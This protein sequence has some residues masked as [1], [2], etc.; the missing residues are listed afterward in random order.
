MF[1]GLN[2]VYLM[3]QKS[4]PE[5]Y[6]KYLN[7]DSSSKRQEEDIL[8]DG[9]G[10]VPEKVEGDGPVYDYIKMS[11]KLQYLHKTYA[12]GF[13]VTEELF[14]DDQYDVIQK[15]AGMLS[16]AVKQTCDTLGAAVLNNAFSGS[17]LGVDGKALCATDHPQSK[18]GGTN[19]N[20]PSVDCDFD[21]ASLQAATETFETWTDAN[22]NPMLYTPKYVISGPLQRDIIVKT[23]GSQQM[24][25]TTD[26]EI[27]AIKE[28]ELQMMILHYLSDTDAWFVTSVPAQ[29][30]MKWFWRK[31]PVFRNF[32]DPST[33]NA[34]FLTRF[35]MS[36]GFTSWQGVY[37]ST[38]V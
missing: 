33:G 18:A 34:R 25:F 27:N 35:R 6:T 9:F 17:Y 15:A 14:E 11:D 1:P 10:L 36:C 32:D 23:L 5:E 20:K 19:A 2:K 3:T 16:I 28:L 13:E 21:P 31:K 30:F 22:G 37:G 24:P 8:I 29:H 12:L 4:Y 38:G 7:M 26:N